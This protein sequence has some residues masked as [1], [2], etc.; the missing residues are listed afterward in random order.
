MAVTPFVAVLPLLSR[1]LASYRA[2][3]IASPVPQAALT[4]R[5]WQQTQQ[6]IREDV[7]VSIPC[8][9]PVTFSQE[10]GF[11]KAVRVFLLE[12]RNWKANF[13]RW[14][15][16]R[17]RL[18]WEQDNLCSNQRRETRTGR[19][20]QPVFLYGMKHRLSPLTNERLRKRGPNQTNPTVPGRKT[21]CQCPGGS[22]M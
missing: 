15:K 13:S 18:F 4:M 12:I 6:T 14:A 11:A 20:S 8:N 21:H 1:A 9:L 10:P 7:D 5:S 17:S 22:R 3:N 16:W 2:A 19:W